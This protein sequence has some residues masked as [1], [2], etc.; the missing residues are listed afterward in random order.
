MDSRT[1]WLSCVPSV[2]SPLLS[3]EAREDH[4][5]V[6]GRRAYTTLFRVQSKVIS[7]AHAVPIRLYFLSLRSSY[8]NDVQTR[9]SSRSLAPRTSTHTTTTPQLP[10]GY[11]PDGF[12]IGTLDTRNE[13]PKMA[14][15]RRRNSK[16]RQRATG[17]TKERL[18]REHNGKNTRCMVVHPK[19]VLL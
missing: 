2:C 5:W 12:L 7:V 16:V 18:Q 11:V 3:D 14:E 9:F 15:Q 8:G 10:P 4:M 17:P 19:Y 1:L 6:A 13:Q